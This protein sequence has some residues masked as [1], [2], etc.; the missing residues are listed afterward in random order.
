[1]AF[2]S[3]LDRLWYAVHGMLETAIGIERRWNEGPWDESEIS[4]I[5]E[6]VGV[7]QLLDGLGRVVFISHSKNLR[8]RLLQHLR[9]GDIAGVERFRWAEHHSVEEAYEVEEELTEEFGWRLG[10][11]RGHCLVRVGGLTQMSIPDCG[12]DPGPEPVVSVVGIPS[13]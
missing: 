5:R 6:T 2:V 7:Y 1:M 10:L 9:E 12:R 8:S 3:T 11:L 13:S 4:Q